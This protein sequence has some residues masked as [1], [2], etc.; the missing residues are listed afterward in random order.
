MKN[1]FLLSV[2][3]IILS[4]GFLASCGGGSAASTVTEID[5]GSSVLGT[6]SYQSASGSEKSSFGY[7]I[8][9]YVDSETKFHFTVIK[10]YS[11]LA[12]SIFTYEGQITAIEKGIATCFPVFMNAYLD[13]GAVNEAS[14]TAATTA[15]GAYK[16]EIPNC[17]DGD[18]SFKIAF[19]RTS[20]DQMANGYITDVNADFDLSFGTFTAVEA[21]SA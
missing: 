10:D 15:F 8:D 12:A 19:H 20:N 1:K 13:H 14:T 21:L 18:T 3:T 5:L 11:T 17:F 16:D 6:W 9:L 4:Y 7:K 2:A